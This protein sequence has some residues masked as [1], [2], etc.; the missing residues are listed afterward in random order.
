MIRHILHT[1]FRRPDG[2]TGRVSQNGGS[3]QCGWADGTVYADGPKRLL[4]SGGETGKQKLS[5]DCS[6]MRFAR[7]AALAGSSVMMRNVMLPRRLSGKLPFILLYYY[8][9]YYQIKKL[10]FCI[11]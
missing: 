2:Q 10:F 3:G 11:Y 8:I 1:G 7:P 6:L 5:G 4:H 9:W